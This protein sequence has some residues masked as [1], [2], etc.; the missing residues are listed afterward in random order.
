M[1]SNIRIG[2]YTIPEIWKA[3]V[4]FATAVVAQEGTIVAVAQSTHVVPATW[5]HGLVVGLGVVSG[6]LTFAK[7]NAAPVIPATPPAPPAP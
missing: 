5:I 4:A 1:F 3:I 2:K 7:S 6:V